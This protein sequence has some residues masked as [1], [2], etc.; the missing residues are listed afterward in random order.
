MD[1]TCNRI[2]RLLRTGT[3]IRQISRELNVSR[4]MV[5]KVI[6]AHHLSRPKQGSSLDEY[7]G[8]IRELLAVCPALPV[9]RVHEHLKKIGFSGSNTIVAERVRRITCPTT[10]PDKKHRR[11]FT[12]EKLKLWL[13][14]LLMSK[15]MAATI[16]DKVRSIANID[17]ILD[18]A[19]NGSKSERKRALAILARSIG[20]SER[21]TAKCL[22]V[23]RYFVNDAYCANNR[24]DANGPFNAPRRRPRRSEI[25]RLV[26]KSLVE[27][28]HHQPKAYGINRTSWT[29]QSLAD[30]YELEHGQKISSN[31]VRTHLKVAGYRWK[32]SRRVLTSPDP[33][34]R[35]KVELLLRSLQSLRTDEVLFFVDELGP[36]QVKRYGGR[37]YSTK[38]EARTHPQKQ[39]SKGSITLYGALSAT[40]NQVTWLYGDA[41]DTTAMIDL[42]EI[43]FNQYQDKSR[44]FITWDAAS[45]HRSNQL[46][47]WVDDLNATSRASKA[48]PVVE[49]LPLPHCAQ[50]LNVIESV[51]SGMKRAVVHNSDYQSVGE[52]KTAISRHFQERNLYFTDNPNRAGKRIWEIDFFDDFDN[53]RS[54]LYRQY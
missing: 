51:F 30:A 4:Y 33:E 7:E 20:F 6:S 26:S 13:F 11:I 3:T 15:G 40:T 44:I 23:S 21:T 48:G 9:K 22:N 35:E 17:R 42:A 28:L 27:I 18:K 50:F 54:G 34:Y 47:E 24:D 36:L 41:K 45:W 32:K 53:L 12:E 16:P 19:R 38:K 31:T 43:L 52:M 5:S 39:S 14:D 8:T 49:L 10:S 1:R 25:R 46:I 37:S 2:L 29:H